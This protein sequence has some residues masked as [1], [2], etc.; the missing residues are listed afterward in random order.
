MRI[1]DWSSD[2]C[3]SDLAPEP[4]STPTT[5]RRSLSDGTRGNLAPEDRSGLIDVYL[6]DTGA[7]GIYG[8][9][10]TE[11]WGS[12]LSGFLVIDD[13]FEDFATPSLDSMKVTL[14]HEF[15][16]LSQFSTDVTEDQDRKST[17][18]NSST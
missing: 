2:V 18:L 13:D 17:R 8:Y 10:E 3:S 7:Q 5:S 11:G 9:A 15:L 1:S 16:H 14:A 6:G 4:G 12:R